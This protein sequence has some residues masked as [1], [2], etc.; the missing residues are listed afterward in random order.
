MDWE[1]LEKIVRKLASYKWG[2]P[3]RA[4]T[5]NG[6]K[7]DCV[8]KQQSDYWVLVEA[9]QEHT[10]AKLR[11]DL[12]KF[13]T[14]RPFLF[15]QKIFSECFFVSENDPPESLVTSGTGQNVTVLSLKQFSAL[16]FDYPR[17]SARP[18]GEAVW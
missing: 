7:V 5:I 15:S 11:T 3:A 18:I 12:A 14:V 4:E 1:T 8:L 6:V 10:L 13:A 16:F 17:Y 9:T 2:S